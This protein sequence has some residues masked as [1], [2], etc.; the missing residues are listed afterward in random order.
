M[1][2]S[3]S[4]NAKNTPTTTTTSQIK[5]EMRSKLA[6]KSLINK[7]TLDKASPPLCR[8]ASMRFRNLESSYS[9]FSASTTA[10]T[11]GLG[12]SG[13]NGDL[14][15]SCVSHWSVLEYAEQ[16]L[17]EMQHNI[18]KTNKMIKVAL[19]N[20]NKDQ[21][22]ALRIQTENKALQ[23]QV[24]AATALSTTTIEEIQ[25]A[26]SQLK[27]ELLQAEQDAKVAREQTVHLQADAQVLT[28]QLDPTN[29]VALVGEATQATNTTAAVEPS[30]SDNNEEDEEGLALPPLPVYDPDTSSSRRG[31][32][33]STQE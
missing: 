19:R 17:E 11:T 18:R 4:S 10:D 24:V 25:S 1:S 29:L 8:N 15:Q 3:R 5:Q 12:S 30:Y 13:V 22:A 31:R 27:G 16:T 26:C 23:R 32:R 2:M 33:S 9:E 20:R 14:N 6:A 28:D 7:K 21:E